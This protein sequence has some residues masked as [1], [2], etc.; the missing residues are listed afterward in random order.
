MAFLGQR[1]A[2]PPGFEIAA[3]VVLALI[4]LAIYLLLQEK[5]TPPPR[6]TV[7][8]YNVDDTEQVFVGCQLKGTVS[9]RGDRTFDLG[10]LRPSEIVTFQLRNRR[11]G[12]TWGY[13]LRVG[14]RKIVSEKQGVVDG[15]G[16]NGNDQSRR[17]QLVHSVSVTVAGK[18][19][20][21]P[22]CL[23]GRDP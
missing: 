1:G 23:V 22:S 21:R 3:V 11:G 17:F 18:R 10:V 15:F 13:D 5:E 16:A 4:G 8:L 14:Q 19:A 20:P 7:H 2:K 9:A 6:T 12:Y